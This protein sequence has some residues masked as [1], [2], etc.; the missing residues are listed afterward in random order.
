MKPFSISQYDVP[1]TPAN[2]KEHENA[3]N[4]LMLKS[5]KENPD[6]AAN[7]NEAPT[8]RST[9]DREGYIC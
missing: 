1:K 4:G 8:R 6:I 2:C 7:N 3:P 9:V 5:I